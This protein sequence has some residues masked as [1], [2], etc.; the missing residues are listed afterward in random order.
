[1]EILARL[2]Q[3]VRRYSHSR[4]EKSIYISTDK[5]WNSRNPGQNN[6]ARHN[7]NLW[8][9]AASAS[10]AAPSPP[11]EGAGTESVVSRVAMVADDQDLEEGATTA[12]SVPAFPGAEGYGANSV[13]GRGGRVS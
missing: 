2:S 4:R 5:D 7:P 8:E 1:M 11:Q 12:P 10:L 9:V 6:A 3:E 13:G